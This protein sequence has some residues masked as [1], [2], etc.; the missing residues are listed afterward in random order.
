MSLEHLKMVLD[1]IGNA[2]EAAKPLLYLY[3]LKEYFVA[4]L[5]VAVICV[6]SKIIIDTIRSDSYGEK[7]RRSAN[8]RGSW[9]IEEMRRA[10]EVLSEC[11]DYIVNGKS[12]SATFPKE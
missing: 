6:I 7:L 1:V 5:A 3:V 4:L 9:S 2:G 12:V 8:V 11:S 10:Q